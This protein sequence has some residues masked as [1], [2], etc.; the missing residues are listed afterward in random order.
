MTFA[1]E[2]GIAPVSG[3]RGR[4]A[5]EFPLADMA[6]GDS[7]LISCDTQEKKQ[8]ESWRR[9][10]M[11]AKKRLAQAYNSEFKFTTAVVAGG[12]RVWRSA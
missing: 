10:L 6:V 1:I 12:L 4:K 5:T 8:V 3:K 2:S 7:F 9:K 11:V